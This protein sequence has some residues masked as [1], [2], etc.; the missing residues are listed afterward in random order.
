MSFKRQHISS[1]AQ[2]K[3][4]GVIFIVISL[5]ELVNVLTGRYLNQFGL[6]P[7]DTASLAGIFFSPFLHGSF[8]HYLSN[9]VPLCIFSLLML[10]HGVRRFF[11]VTLS[12]IFFSGI[13]VWLFGRSAVHVGASGLIYGYFSYLLI[14]GILSRQIK[15]V[16][17]VLVVGVSYGGLVWGVLPGRAFISW[18]SHLFGMVIGL[19]CALLWARESCEIKVTAD[20]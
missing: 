9:I 2:L 19:L 3:T 18:E 5:V 12:C 4:V 6:V 20:R 17:I 7:R 8:S 16:I 11:L 13:L 14:G 15:L 1:S 10:Q